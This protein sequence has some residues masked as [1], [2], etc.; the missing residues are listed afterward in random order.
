MN[1]VYH[2][3]K[4]CETGELWPLFSFN[5]ETGEKEAV[6]YT[7]YPKQPFKI[8]KHLQKTT[9]EAP[10]RQTYY[11]NNTD[12]VTAFLLPTAILFFPSFT[13]LMWLIEYTLHAWSHKQNSKNGGNIYYF[14]PLH[15][16]CK[17]FCS[18][19][20]EETMRAKF[21]KMQDIRKSKLKR[22]GLEYVRRVVT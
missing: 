10:L 17:E 8:P 6:V 18:K 21:S 9:N 19:C 16:I 13:V 14:S 11:S 1:F 2:Y 15:Q 5:E 22:Y 3:E 7:K 12:V 4:C 20:K